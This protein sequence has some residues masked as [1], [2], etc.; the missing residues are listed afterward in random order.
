[1]TPT[2]ES[3]PSSLLS[4]VEDHTVSHSG[5]YAVIQI[6]SHTEVMHIL[7]IYAP[8]T[9]K[10]DREKFFSA[11]QEAPCMQEPSILAVG[12]WNYVSDRLDRLNINGHSDPT[13]HPLSEQFLESHELIDIFGYYDDEA[14][15]M[16]YKSEGI[17]RWARLD[18]WYAQPDLMDDCM[19][20]SNISAAGVSG[21]EIIRLQYGNHFKP[22]TPLNPVYGCQL[23]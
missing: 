10:A 3:Y 19:V 5:R 4:L 18:R 6:K 15:T 16:T 7:N 9:S 17:Q 14:V 12:D 1:M 23:P 20:L 22:N 8:P 11:L 21:H 2:P 13:P